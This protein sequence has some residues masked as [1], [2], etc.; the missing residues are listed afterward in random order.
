[1][2]LIIYKVSWAVLFLR[3]WTYPHDPCPRLL[4]ASKNLEKK[5]GQNNFEK[6]HKATSNIVNDFSNKF[7]TKTQFMRKTGFWNFFKYWVSPT[8][9]HTISGEGEST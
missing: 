9:P 6:K 2:Q 4:K 7:S 8:A 5:S 3:F 1:M